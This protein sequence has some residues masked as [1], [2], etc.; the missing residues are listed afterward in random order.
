[1]RVCMCVLST[2]SAHAFRCFL[3]RMRMY[4]CVYIYTHTNVLYRMRM[5]VDMLSE[6]EDTCMRESVCVVYWYSFK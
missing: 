5:C 4:V 6:E 2:S 1:M 3:K